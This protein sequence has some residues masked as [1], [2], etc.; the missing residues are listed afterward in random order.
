MVPRFEGNIATGSEARVLNEQTALRAAADA[1]LA[2]RNAEMLADPPALFD[3]LSGSTHRPSPGMNVCPAFYANDS[4][5][6]AA[7]EVAMLGEGATGLDDYPAFFVSL[8]QTAIAA[9][10]RADRDRLAPIQRAA[11]E[12]MRG[13]R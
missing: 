12:A 13:Q 11:T 5:V 4:L 6:D 8:V 7:V 1:L 10:N 2:T 3:I 9:K